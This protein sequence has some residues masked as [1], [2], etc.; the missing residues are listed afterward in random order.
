MFFEKLSCERAC[1]VLLKADPW[2]VK[3]CLVR[4][5]MDGTPQTVR[6]CFCIAI[7]LYW[8]SL[9]FIKRNTPKNFSWSSGWFWLPP[10]TPAHLEEPYCSARLGCCYWL[11]LGVCYWTGY[12]VS[13][14]WR[15]ESPQG[16]TSKQAQD[17]LFI[18]SLQ[19]SMTF[20]LLITRKWPQP[21]E[22]S[23]TIRPVPS[24]NGW[25]MLETKVHPLVAIGRSEIQI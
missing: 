24:W 23:V 3:C 10:L 6:G 14:Q 11:V 16:T 19:L 21:E 25:D 1:D 9:V 13:K 2:E 8:S 15:V 7:R 12:L 4:I 17:T 18:L 5:E 20:Y 22:L